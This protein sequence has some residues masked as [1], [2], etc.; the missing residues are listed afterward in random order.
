M[1]M[2]NVIEIE[3]DVEQAKQGL[4]AYE[5]YL[6]NGGTLSEEDW[7]ESLKGETPTIGENGNWFIGDIDT[8]LPSKG[9]QGE[10]GSVKF[11]PVTE[12]PTENIDNTAIYV[13]PS[14]KPDDKN[15]YEEFIYVNGDWEPFG[16]GGITVN[17]DDYATK[18]ELNSSVGELNNTIGNI[19]N[20]STEDKSSLVNA[21]NEV[22]N[23]GSGSCALYHYRRSTD[24][25]SGSLNN[26]DKNKLGEILTDAYKKGLDDIRINISL[27]DTSSY[28]Y[29]FDRQSSKSIQDKPT[30]IY[31]FGVGINK[32]YANNTSFYL[33]IFQLTV[34]VTWSDDGVCTIN[35]GTLYLTTPN[36]LTKDNTFAYTPTGDYHPA[37]KKYVDDSLSNAGEG[38]TEITEGPVKID[39]LEPGVY[40]LVGNLKLQ[41]LNGGNFS[42]GVDTCILT[43]FQDG[44]TKYAYYLDNL[45][46]LTVV[47]ANTYTTYNFDQ[48]AT[49]SY[50][51]DATG[52]LTTLATEDKTNLVNAI[53]E[54]MNSGGE[55]VMRYNEDEFDASQQKTGLYI[56]GENVDLFT[57][58]ASTSKGNL[59]GTFV[60]VYNEEDCLTWSAMVRIASNYKL[61]TY[62]KVTGGPIYNNSVTLENL[63]TTTAKQSISGIKTFTKLPESSI[64]PTTDNQLVNKKYV[65]NAIT[66]AIT[67]VLEGEY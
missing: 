64:V 67:T 8:G 18:E 48:M 23:S 56:L 9:P 42:T 12:L 30:S 35:F 44:T 6:A 11:I 54:V 25:S 60:A 58:V 28:S 27:N 16:A 26:H 59:A 63:V 61:V 57:T 38:I 41:L 4:S 50:V 34:D 20:L 36:M 37:T 53:N 46:R 62:H 65:D 52:D 40:K 33:N 49:T 7:L 51:D 31:W 55:S 1:E 19:E 5:V 17:L 43:V 10:P 39:D 47:Y 24:S 13:K 32:R 15:K 45:K 21:I 3:V 22:V 14:E 2:E 29:N 66:A